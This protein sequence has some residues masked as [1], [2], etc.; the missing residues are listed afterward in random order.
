M[1]LCLFKCSEPDSYHIYLIHL[2][3]ITSTIF[4]SGTELGF[5]SSSLWFHYLHG[6]LKSTSTTPKQAQDC[7]GAVCSTDAKERMI[8]A[9]P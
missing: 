4:C 8:T 6:S 1:P 5:S 2:L 3:A 9:P 7:L